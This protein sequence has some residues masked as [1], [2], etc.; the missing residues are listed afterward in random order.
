MLCVI[1]MCFVCFERADIEKHDIALGEP[2]V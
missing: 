2:L 1:V